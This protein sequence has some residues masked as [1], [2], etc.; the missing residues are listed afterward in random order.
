[1]DSKTRGRLEA[2]A[3]ELEG[4]ARTIPEWK[5]TPA[6]ETVTGLFASAWDIKQI[7]RKGTASEG[8]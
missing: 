3:D 4:I 7:A 2:I 5:E 8:L 1:M 6:N